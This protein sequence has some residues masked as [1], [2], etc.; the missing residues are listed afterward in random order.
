MIMN[1]FVECID[2]FKNHK[3]Y[4]TDTDSLYIDIDSFNILKK[5]SLI[6]DALG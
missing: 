2:G 3:V 1:R 5:N 4:Y 6:G